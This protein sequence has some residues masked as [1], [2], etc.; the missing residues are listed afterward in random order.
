MHCGRLVSLLYGFGMRLMDG[1]RLRVKDQ[2]AQSHALWAQ[3]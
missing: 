3:K 1:L 2:F